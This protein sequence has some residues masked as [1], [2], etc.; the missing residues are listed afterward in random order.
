MQIPIKPMERGA[1]WLDSYATKL[2]YLF[3]FYSF[4]LR[5]N[6]H[7]AYKSTSAYCSIQ[8]ILKYDCILLKT[9]NR[10]PAGPLS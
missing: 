3:T 7:H 10:N 2:S 8:L 1:M 6:W 5:R 9:S 4:M